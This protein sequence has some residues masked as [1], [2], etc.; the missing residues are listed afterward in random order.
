[1][2]VSYTSYSALAISYGIEM[3]AASAT[4]Q[5][6]AGVITSTAAK[7]SIIETIGGIGSTQDQAVSV[8]GGV[9]TVGS[10]NFAV[11]HEDTFDAEEIALHT[12]GY[13]G[14]I[15]IDL[16][17]PLNTGD[18]APEMMRRMRNQAGGIKADMEALFGQTGYLMR[19]FI[20]EHGYRILD[21]TTDFKGYAVATLSVNWSSP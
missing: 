12:F 13:K 21:E 9:I 11:V 3:L 16:L 4:F 6:L 20:T 19:G 10:A 1:M 15:G 14:V 18:T 7:S 17:M 8:G 5:A 2:T